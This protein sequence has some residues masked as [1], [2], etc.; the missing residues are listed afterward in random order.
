[1]NEL[2]LSWD[3]KSMTGQSNNVIKDQVWEPTNFL[4]ITYRSLGN[5]LVIFM[6][7]WHKSESSERREPELRKCLWFY[8]RSP[9]SL[10]FISLS[11]QQFGYEFHLTE[12]D[13][14]QTSYWLVTLISFCYHWPS[15]SCRQARQYCRSKGL[16][17]SWF[18]VSFF[19]A[20]R[21]ASCM[22]HRL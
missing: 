4:E 3:G 5:V 1:M 18:Y 13:L 9:G 12:E 6:S 7:A 17:L 10:F 21:T 22:C 2:L 15:L 14:N 19:I 8:P 11:P 16:W 20:C